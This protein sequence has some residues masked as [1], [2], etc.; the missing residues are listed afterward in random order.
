[1]Q[2]IKHVWDKCDLESHK[3]LLVSL[4]DLGFIYSVTYIVTYFNLIFMFDLKMSLFIYLHFTLLRLKSSEPGF[5]TK[6]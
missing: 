2:V 3:H 1:M 4:E 5:H 6:I